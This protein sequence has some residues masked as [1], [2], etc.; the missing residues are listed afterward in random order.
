MNKQTILNAY[1]KARE[2]HVLSVFFSETASQ[3][4]LNSGF[5]EYFLR[6]KRQ[7][8]TFAARLAVVQ[9]TKRNAPSDNTPLS[10]EVMRAFGA[11]SDY[12]YVFGSDYYTIK[13]PR[14]WAGQVVDWFVIWY[15]KPMRKDWNLILSDDN[16][17]TFL[18]GC[19]TIGD[20]KALYR[21]LTDRELE[22]KR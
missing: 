22:V 11:K 3:E 8:E 21:M 13:I 6:V 7:V 10:A 17:H 14:L 5:A 18:P 1:F 2:R 15:D 16:Q 12:S 9:P 19:R 20:L 4:D